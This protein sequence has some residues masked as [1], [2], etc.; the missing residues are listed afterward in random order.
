[1]TQLDFA[2]LQ[3]GGMTGYR[4]LRLQVRVGG[5]AR[6]CDPAVATT[7]PRACL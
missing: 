1:V 4:P 6:V 3:P 5:A 2:S 7:D